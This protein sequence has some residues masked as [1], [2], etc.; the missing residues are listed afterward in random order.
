MAGLWQRLGRTRRRRAIAAFLIAF[1]VLAG[2]SFRPARHLLRAWKAD[3]DDRDAT[4]A[5]HIDDAS[6]L[7]VTAVAEVWPVPADAKQAEA[8][9]KELLARAR[10]DQLKVSIAGARH[11]MG[12]HAIATGGIVVDMLPFRAMKLNA[13]KDMLHVQ[14]GARWSDVIPLLD[15]YGRSPWVMQSNNSFSVGG[16]LSVNCHGWQ[17]D[18]PPIASTVE[19]FRLMLADGQIVRC[20]RDENA[21]LFS[22]ALGGYGLFG[23]IL[24]AELRVVPNEKYRVKQFI[25]PAE[26][27]L[28][29][30]QSNAPGRPDVRMVY[31]RLN[32]ARERLFRDVI[33][34][35]FHQEAGDPPPLVTTEADAL[36]RLIFRGSAQDDYGKT[37]RWDAETRLNPLIADAV[38]SRNQL[39]NESVTVFE[40]R[41]NKTT[42]IL[43]EY[44]V[45][46][47]QAGTFVLDVTE[48]LARH[49][50][51]LLNV[52]VRQINEDRDSF[53]RYADQPIFSFVMLLVQERTPAGE[54][55]MRALT[56]ELI[57][58]SLKRGGRYYLPYRLH[59]T[60]E[61]FRRAY[62]QSKEFFE[63]KR[64][65]DPDEVFWNEFYARYGADA[66]G[67]SDT[68]G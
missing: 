38:V 10:R 12:G 45:P 40:N 1:A 60:P 43:H 22:L 29:T 42:D 66:Q 62:P 19:S 52:T 17:F 37:L 51:D 18:R 25:V 55:R 15:V 53:L 65:Y 14:A 23:I 27:A 57:E 31:A 35:C 63:K 48:I 68:K 6:R 41:S 4:P 50:P 26:E 3:V 11:S 58:A 20:S 49:K 59:A 61:Q 24:D 2:V 44:F 9:L 34:T 36:R 32:V 13:A 39:F 30:F 21:E 8:H 16:S 64:E 46:Q 33:I 7:N 54:E 5:G 56:Q 47:Q 28:A 67:D